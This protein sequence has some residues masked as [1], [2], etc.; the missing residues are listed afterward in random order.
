MRK[1]E[2]TAAWAPPEGLCK[3]ERVVKG[4]DRAELEDE[5]K[6]INRGLP[7]LERKISFGFP[8]AFSN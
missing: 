6:T 4:G 5:R 3:E 8:Y 7:C 1:L 2:Q